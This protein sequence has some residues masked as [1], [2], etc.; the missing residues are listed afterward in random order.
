M[1]SFDNV[2]I[3]TSRPQGDPECERDKRS[4]VEVALHHVGWAHV[5]RVG[6]VAELP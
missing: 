6:I 1:T 5:R 3:L 4:S 2:H